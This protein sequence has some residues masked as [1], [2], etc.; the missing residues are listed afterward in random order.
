MSIHQGDESPPIESPKGFTLSNADRLRLEIVASWFNIEY[1]AISADRAEI[2]FDPADPTQA[3]VVSMA[4][5]HKR[6]MA[7]V[8]S[9]AGPWVYF[10]FG[11]SC[12]DSLMSLTDARLRRI[13]DLYRLSLAQ[14][15]SPA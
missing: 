8:C 14:P 15:H 6:L 10:H 1:R 5:A 13:G 12:R 4:I 9:R 11:M 7:E 3:V 2:S